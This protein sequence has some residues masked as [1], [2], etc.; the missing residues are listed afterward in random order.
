MHLGAV[1]AGLCLPA[2][3]SASAGDVSSR[4]KDVAAART[5]ADPLSL[6]GER[7]LHEHVPAITLVPDETVRLS[8]GTSLTRL[9]A[10]GNETMRFRHTR[11]DVADVFVD[12]DRDGTRLERTSGGVAAHPASDVHGPFVHVDA[13]GYRVRW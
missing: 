6:L 8:S 13:R 9:R 5:L 11:A 2:A 3:G 12:E 4:G 1:V 10:V 7:R